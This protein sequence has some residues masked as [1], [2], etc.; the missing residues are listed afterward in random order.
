M[1]IVFVE[2]TEGL[3]SNRGDDLRKT[4]KSSLERGQSHSSM[5]CVFIVV[6]PGLD[7]E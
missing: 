3:V 6:G 2:G 1:N 5:A 7:N 4:L